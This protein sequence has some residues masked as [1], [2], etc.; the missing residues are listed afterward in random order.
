M[1][2]A[3]LLTLALC[4]LALP[5]HAQNVWNSKIDTFGN[6]VR[7]SANPTANGVVSTFTPATAITVTRIQLQGINQL[8]TYPCTTP[9]GIKITNGTSTVALI[10][11]NGPNNGQSNPVSNDT[12][13]ISVAFPAGTP[14]TLKAVPGTSCNPYEINIVV[15][16]SIP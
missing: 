14:I 10:I 4:L 3:F 1:K 12:G 16:Y 5:L 2:K 9:A 6:F 11:P 7:Q 8:P 15:Q 13:V